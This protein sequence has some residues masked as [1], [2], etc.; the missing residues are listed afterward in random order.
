[1]YFQLGRNENTPLSDD[2]FLRAHWIMFHQFGG[3][4]F[5]AIAGG[6]AFQLTMRAAAELQQFIPMPLHKEQHPGNGTILLFVRLSKA[7]PADVDMEATGAGLVGAIAQTNGL[8]QNVG[9]RHVFQMMLHGH[10]VGHDLDPI[11]QRAVVLAVNI[12]CVPVSDGQ[13]FLGIGLPSSPFRI[14]CS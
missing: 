5:V 11:F 14:V 4:I 8:G 6:P 7:I 1:M 12:F 3:M 10:R 13:T 9:P 2:E